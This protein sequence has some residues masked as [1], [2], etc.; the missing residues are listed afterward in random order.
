[1]EKHFSTRNSQSSGLRPSYIGMSIVL[2]VTSGVCRGDSLLAS[3]HEIVGLVSRAFGGGAGRV[4][5]GGTLPSRRL[6]SPAVTGDE[7]VCG[8][9][10]DIGL[11]NLT[12]VE[13]RPSRFVP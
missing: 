4:E 10:I 9:A 13:F 3:T 12:G 2:V 1:M 8:G 7:G 6:F 11:E 5:R